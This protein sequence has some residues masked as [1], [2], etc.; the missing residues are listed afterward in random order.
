M[1]DALLLSR[2]D[3]EEVLDFPSVIDALDAA[4]RSEG[5]AEW[6]TPK[7]ISA[8][9]KGGA[10]LAMPCAGGAPEA[11]GAKLVSTFAGNTAMNE[12]SV[13][14]LYVLFDP[15]TGAPLC[16]MDGLYLTLVRTAAVSAL[17][18]RLLS[19]PDAATLGI[20][21]AGAQAEIHARLIA[22]VRPVEKVVIWA[23]RKERAEALAAT[24]RGSPE[25]RQVSLWVVSESSAEAAACD[26]VVTATAAAEPV[27]AGR[28]LREGSHVNAIGAH[29]KN[30]REMDSEAVARASVLA[31]ESAD[32][33]AEAG[34]FL[35]A[36][37][38]IGGV[39]SRAL[40]L[41][42]LLERGELRDPRAIS[43]FKSCGVAFEDLAVA[44]LAHRR[45]LGSKLGARF[46]FRDGGKPA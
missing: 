13:S 15:S 8:R 18:T 20:L 4:F 11:L 17:A 25:L 41:S 16:V 44:S 32:T 23:R 12:P 43:I 36:D 42:T 38:E 37:A 9:T 6:D 34:D 24:L 21:G 31:V 27:L 14:G 22:S 10:L 5:R 33:L 7:R 39:V 46:S 45:A 40:P 2:R 28:N 3:L 19:R 1:Q 26:I 35:M 29:A 30:H